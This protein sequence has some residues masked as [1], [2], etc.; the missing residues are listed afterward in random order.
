MCSKD[1]CVEISFSYV[2][3]IV[4]KEDSKLLPDY[5]VWIRSLSK[6]LQKQYADSVK[7]VKFDLVGKH[8]RDNCVK[9]GS[10]SIKIRR[11]SCL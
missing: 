6:K 8:L 3:F 7:F 4:I 11:N 5:R 9:D 10:T 1:K 2:I